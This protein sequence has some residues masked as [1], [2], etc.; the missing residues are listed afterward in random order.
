MTFVKIRFVKMILGIITF[1]IIAFGKNDILDSDYYV[2]KLFKI[3]N[4]NNNALSS[5]CKPE[6]GTCAIKIFTAITNSMSK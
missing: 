3:N 1:G 5:R 6:T 4:S 2:I